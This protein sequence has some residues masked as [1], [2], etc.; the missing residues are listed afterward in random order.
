MW[1]V[2]NIDDKAYSYNVPK[3]TDSTLSAITVSPKE[4]IGFDADRESYEV[5]VASTVSQATVAAT[6]NFSEAM[7]EITPADADVA[8]GHQIDLTAGATTVTF[9]VTAQ[10][11][12]TMK[13]YTVNINRGRHR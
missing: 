5:G 2:D 3:S 1:V 11:D 10:D 12:T 7:V 4:I 8:D 9:V 6:T 13:T